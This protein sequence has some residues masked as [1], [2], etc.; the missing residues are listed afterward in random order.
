MFNNTKAKE[1]YEVLIGRIEGLE[2]AYSAIEIAFSKNQITV[3]QTIRLECLKIA[4]DIAI[5]TGG[6]DLVVAELTQRLFEYVKNGKL[7]SSE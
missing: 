1:L 2:Q 5:Q 4:K 7:E 6:S 3:D